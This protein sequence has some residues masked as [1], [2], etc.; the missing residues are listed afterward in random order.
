MSGIADIT[1]EDLVNFT[2]L[3]E[4]TTANDSDIIIVED[5]ENT[6]KITIVN[7]RKSM[8]MDNQN[9]GSDRLWSSEKINTALETL[10]KNVEKTVGS[11]KET[12]EDL[13]TAKVS[14]NYVDDKLLT[15]D[16]KKAN[17]TI[18]EALSK[19]LENKLPKNS[20][21][22]GKDIK[23]TTDGDK[24]HMEHL[25]ADILTAMTGNAPVSMATV[26][27]GGW[28]TEDLGDG[29]IIASKLGSSYRFKKNVTEGNINLITDDGLYLL[30]SGVTGFPTY[31][32]D[33][34]D[35]KLL[36]VE[37]YGE[38]GKYI[39]QTVYYIDQPEYTEKRPYKFERAGE[40][41]KIHTLEF[42]SH[43]EVTDVNK[44]EA[45]LLGDTY[46][47]RGVISSG[48]VYDLAAN[49]NYL[50]TK[51][52]TSLPLENTNFLVTIN[53]YNETTEFTAKTVETTGGT[54]EY[55]SFIYY[56]S[57]H[58]PV[59]APWFMTA[60]NL[61]SKFDGK[62]VHVFGD[63]IAYGIGAS[64]INDTSLTALLSSKYGYAIHNHSLP[65]ATYGIYDN[66]KYK[67]KCI[68]TQAQ[69]A[70]GI[71]DGDYAI[72]F[73]G[74]NDF[75][76]GVAQIGS[77]LSTG[78]ATFKGSISETISTLLTAN[79]SL[80]ILLVTPI[81]RGSIT[82]GDGYNSDETKINDKY[83]SEFAEAIV[84][85]GKYYHIPTINLYDECTINKYTKDIYLNDTGIYPTDTGYELLCEK[86]HDAMCRFY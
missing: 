23:C 11:M 40:L 25:G 42:S 31:E 4:K 39:R 73:A 80:K 3:I 33:E 77:N 13:D 6:K 22:T 69:L 18:T 61:K 45:D 12:V 20:T 2:D 52:V 56:D 36:E 85:I 41:S 28:Q 58:M 74:T 79:P 72:I 57:A 64:S 83:L 44:V 71:T 65:D 1:T 24:L 59:I 37:R 29:I 7:L 47:N 14:K 62:R 75:T 63:G 27:S 50:C 10:Q 54:K 30:G 38:E 34:T 49:G 68:L 84:E 78:T 15:L 66:D 76:S 46:N 70:S 35:P 8:I 17:V 51:D 48:D 19:E 21:F 32:A 67:D 60:S 16:E 26:P 9:P 86:I 53:S 55:T 81:Y 82:S 5:S 43:F